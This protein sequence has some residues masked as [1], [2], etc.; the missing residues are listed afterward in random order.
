M[1]V[2][3]G[4]GAIGRRLVIGLRRQGFIVRCLVHRRPVNHADEQVPGSLDDDAALERAVFGADAVVH[5][6]GTTHA[7]DAREYERVNA[8]G[9]AH[10]VLAA[11][12]GGV[13]RF[14]HAGT[15]AISPEG[16]AYS[17]SKLRAETSVRRSSL[18]YTILRL[19]EVYGA[20][21]KEGIDRIVDGARKG[22]RI[23]IVG[24]GSNRICP[25]HIDDAVAAFEAAVSTPAAAG[26][27][28][29]VG[30]TCVTV[31][32]FAEGCRRAFG[33]RSRVIRIPRVAVRVA[34]SSARRLPLPLYPDQLNRLL[35]PKDDPSPDALLDLRFEPRPLSEGLRA[36]D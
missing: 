18:E 28:Y 32:E 17:V 9:T 33:S 13:R 11:E 16:G 8:E 10:L 31:L 12:Q 5:L 27:T 20:G 2:T 19:A 7:R 3:G 30:G 14:V 35:S 24:D 34:A 4:S 22:K 36:A 21:G 25:I 6:A 26:K 23:P 29:T 1:L 15:R